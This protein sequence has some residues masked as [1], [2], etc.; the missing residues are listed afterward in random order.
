MPNANRLR[1]TANKMK[2]IAFRQEQHSRNNTAGLP[3]ACSHSRHTVHNYHS[4]T[5]SLRKPIN[6]WPHFCPEPA[7]QSNN[8][9]L[10]SSRKCANCHILLHRYIGQGLM[11]PMQSSH[12]RD[13]IR[14]PHTA[15]EHT[16]NNRS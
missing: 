1:A 15:T 11:E 3:E 7:E 10:I 14:L 16:C 8:G 6:L 9:R 12:T 4:T 5:D 2:H 13:S